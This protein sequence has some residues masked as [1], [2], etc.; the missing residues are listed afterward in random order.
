[1]AGRCRRTA[2]TLP[3]EERFADLVDQRRDRGT[4][5]V[6][7]VQQLGLRTAVLSTLCDRDVGCTRRRRPTSGRRA[8]AAFLPGIVDEAAKEE[9][10]ALDQLLLGTEPAG[11]GT[12]PDRS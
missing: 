3:H 9:S 4:K 1:M 12:H 6:V 8:V 7:A 5:A 10:G 2:A 11:G